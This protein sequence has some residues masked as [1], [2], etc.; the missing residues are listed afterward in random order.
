MS[1]LELIKKWYSDC[2]EYYGDG[3]HFEPFD[4]PRMGLVSSGVVDPTMLAITRDNYL[5]NR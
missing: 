4:G 3:F 5:K 1:F 2:K